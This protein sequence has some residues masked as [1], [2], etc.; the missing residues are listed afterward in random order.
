MLYYEVYC[1]CTYIQCHYI[2]SYVHSVIIQ[3]TQCYYVYSHYNVAIYSADTVSQCVTCIGTLCSP[4]KVSLCSVNTVS[5]ILLNYR[6]YTVLLYMHAMSLHSVH[7]Q[8]Q[9]KV[10][11]LSLYTVSLDSVTMQCT[12][13][14]YKIRTVSPYNVHIVTIMVNTVSL[15]SENSVSIWQTQCHYTVYTLSL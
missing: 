11:T 1:R 9:Y 14:P 15:Y 2:A 10:Y 5:L 8:C 12:H 13:F 3:C 4:C 6:A 7:M